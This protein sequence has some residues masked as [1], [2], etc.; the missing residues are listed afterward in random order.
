MRASH[1]HLLYAG[2]G[3]LGTLS[4]KKAEWWGI[5]ETDSSLGMVLSSESVGDVNSPR[6]DSQQAL[7]VWTYGHHD[8]YT[9]TNPDIQQALIAF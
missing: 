2:S 8:I 3:G 4:L 6:L 7:L 5:I 1:L 9:L